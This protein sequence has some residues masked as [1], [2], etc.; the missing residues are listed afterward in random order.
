VVTLHS[1]WV[2]DADVNAFDRYWLFSA[3]DQFSYSRNQSG[4]LSDYERAKSLHLHARVV[5]LEVDAEA[6]KACLCGSVL[7][8]GVSVE[9]SS[10]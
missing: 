4:W 6:L 2:S 1:L 7:T 8:V 3:W 5:V 10:V 9:K